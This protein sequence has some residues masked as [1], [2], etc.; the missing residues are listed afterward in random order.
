MTGDPKHAAHWEK[1]P[2]VLC[3][4]ADH[5]KHKKGRPR[6][7]FKDV[8]LKVC[9]KGDDIIGDKVM[10]HLQETP[11]DIHAADTRY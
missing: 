2:R 11:S 7:G 10:V 4:T 6:K 5:R 8:F 9:Q 3:W 1:N